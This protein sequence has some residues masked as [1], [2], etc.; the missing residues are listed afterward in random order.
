[1][2]MYNTSHL[3]KAFLKSINNLCTVPIIFPFSPQHLT[4]AEYLLSG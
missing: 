3:T 2:K 1:M 4:Y